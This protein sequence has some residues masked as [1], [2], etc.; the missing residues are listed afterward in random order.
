MKHSIVVDMSFDMGFSIS[1]N[2]SGGFLSGNS[3]T[4]RS[5]T[6]LFP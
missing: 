2:N 5:N 6:F 3:I 4:Y 1:F